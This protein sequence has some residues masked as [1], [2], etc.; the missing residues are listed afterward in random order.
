MS[1]Q[2]LDIVSPETV[3]EDKIGI[4]IDPVSLPLLINRTITLNFD[5]SE[6]YPEGVVKPL[7]LQ[8]QPSFGDGEGYF[9]IEFARTIPRSFGF[10]VEGAGEYLVVLR[11]TGHNLWQ[12]RLLIEVGGDKFNQ[13][14]TSR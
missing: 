12:G 10:S 9:E 1:Q 3:G 5:Y 6:T 13:V 14:K 7:K 11:E 8:V 2:L 4:S